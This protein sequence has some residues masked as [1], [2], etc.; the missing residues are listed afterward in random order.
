MKQLIGYLGLIL[1]LA[2]FS[3]QAATYNLSQDQYPECSTSW[4]KTGTVYQC[5]NNGK[6]SLDSGDIVI[7]DV[8]STIKA[9][10]G[11]KFK[12]VTIGS[13]SVAIN[14]ESNDG[15]IAISN[16]STIWGNLESESG[17]IAISDSQVSGLIKT[18]A[19]IDL[20]N[21]QI[22]GE[23]IS[24]NKAIKA[25]NSEI[26]GNV[27]AEQGVDLKGGFVLGRVTSTNKDIDAK[28]TNLLGGATASS[29]IKIDG[30]EHAGQFNLTDLKV[31]DFNNAVLLNGSMSGAHEV[32]IKNSQLGSISEEILINTVTGGIEL[33][34]DSIVYGHLVASALSVVTVKSGSQVYGTCLPSSDPIDACQAINI[35]SPQH[36]YRFDGS[37]WNGTSG[38]VIDSIGNMPGTALGATTAEIGQICRTSQFN[39]SSH[40]AVDNLALLQGTA[41]MSFWIKT[42]A[43]GDN[44]GWR[45]P[46]VA[47]VEQTGGGNDIF[48]GWLDSQGRIGITK[49]N[50][51]N[52]TKSTIAINNNEFRHI[53]LTRQANTGQFQIFIDGQLNNAG[54]SEQGFV[55]NSFNTIGLV[56]HT[57]GTG[58]NYLRAEIDELQLYD[59]I[60]TATEVSHLYQLQLEQ[61]DLDGNIR[62]CGQPL[63]CLADD[64]N[65]GALADT[66]ITSVSR[67]N[68]TPKVVNGRMRM[69]E[70]V[71]NQATS[72]TYQR[73]YP[74]ANNLVIVEFDYWAYG[75]SS[76]DGIALVLSD[77][78]VTPQPGAYGGALGYGFKPG[79]PGFA[80]GWL[81]FGLDE[82]G[83]FSNEGGSYNIGRRRQSVVV[84]GSGSGTSGYRYLQGT[85]NNGTTNVN[86]NCLS[87][88]VDGNQSSPHRYRFVVD[89][90][91][92]NQTLVSVFRDTGSGFQE[93]IAPFNAQSA[94]GQ[95]PVPENFLLSLTGSTG[96]STN[97]HELDNLSI[98]A[99]RSAPVGQQ[100]DHFEFDYSGQALTCS[101]ERFTVRACKNAAC[102]ELVTEPVVADLSPATLA[103]GGWV[104]GNQISFAGGSTEVEF[105]QPVSNPVTIGVSGSVPSTKPLSTTLCRAGSGRLSSA[106]C[107]ITF[108]DS[109]FVFNINDGIAN[110]VE[111]DVIIS[112][113]R[114]DDS[115]Q[116]CI[117]AFADVTRKVAFWSDYITPNAISRPASFPVSVNS[118]DVGITEAEQ[119]LVPL[120]FDGQG[121]AKMTINYADA[122][123][124]QLNARYTGSAENEDTGLV[125]QGADQFIRRPAALCIQTQGECVAAD[126]RCN[127][128]KQAGE[129]FPLTISARAYGPYADV[130]ANPVTPNFVK[131]NIA[132]QHE[133]V[134]PNPGNSG[135]LAETS[136][137]HNAN[138]AGQKV[139]QQS[140]SEVGV[141]KFTTPALSYLTMA[142]PIP[143]AS[144][145]ATGRF[146][147]A[148]FTL[149]A[150]PVV[151][152]CSGS[153][154]YFGQKS[155]ST[156]FSI[157]AVNANARV[158]EN[159]RDDF[160]RLN[161]NQWTDIRDS[162]GVRY[163]APGLP[164][165]SVLA[166]GDMMP[167]GSWSQGKADL[168][169]NHYA[170]RPT[171][172]AAPLEL[173]LYA[174]PLD[175]DGVTSKTGA[176]QAITTSPT[177]LRF[178]RLVMDNAYGPEDMP[179]P[180][181]FY[182]EYWQGSQFVVNNQDSC[183]VITSPS[184]P[185]GV[186]S[187][188]FSL[189]VNDSCNTISGSTALA[190]QGVAGNVDMGVFPAASLSIQATDSSGV[191]RLQYNTEPWLRYNWRD[192]SSGFSQQPQAD[193]H[194]GRFRGNP[195]QIYWRELF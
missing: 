40:I 158:T 60:L 150:G 175:S 55:G 145:I 194:F 43:T 41:S 90:T 24:L 15:D 19:D 184:G 8:P 180:L 111:S 10:K 149:T 68:F 81:G 1:L 125:M 49:G 61:R 129:L 16:N 121:Q 14:L 59:V 99:L 172:L 17:D 126:S 46:A 91:L 51:F 113:V 128:F 56:K 162:Q 69:T 7:A 135:V 82:F 159:Y 35:P 12:G 13:S 58:K 21:A 181:S 139:I 45:A 155:F 25:S 11:F 142:D 169:S 186:Q 53:V 131:S 192:A 77:A 182:T 178:G 190:V 188:P 166:A 157:Q 95:A 110:F 79:I 98:C 173:T 28:N 164:S 151:P 31:I 116:Q 108:A 20:K 42:T 114:K 52:N 117:P 136:Y 84:R 29:G 73:L 171:A 100:I 47:G 62:E 30:G 4:E 101:P 146:I 107:N 123:Q 103:K 65:A 140:V 156:S 70:A 22:G 88:A 93:L 36:E 33:K 34:N 104:G 112:A 120:V 38:E 187:C 87:P 167:I 80:G 54:A 144:S 39:G 168:I 177:E 102:T 78:K 152:A 6:V 48:W 118:T 176:E 63:Q 134:A 183:T 132:L 72:A 161:V 74:A 191:W 23:V 124:M 2:T 66:W 89:S 189:D 18:E 83:N 106:A 85:C 119:T 127:K 163:S 193:I 86:T 143:A 148:Y 115:S 64:F 50:D 105:R 5:I 9:N 195:R 75:G 92:A 71:G 154:S 3:S 76:A 32:R 130:C 185:S 141:F 165:G 138:I 97:I 94:T 122:G 26:Q 147:P 67:G 96:G 109:G 179:I 153:F 44:S 57:N 170:T 160:A 27:T 37:G 137:N 174:T 133:L